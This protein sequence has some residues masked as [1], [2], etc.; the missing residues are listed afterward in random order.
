MDS[1]CATFTSTLVYY[2][3]YLYTAKVYNDLANTWLLLPDYAFS[4]RVVFL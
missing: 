2:V 1:H 3:V 4:A